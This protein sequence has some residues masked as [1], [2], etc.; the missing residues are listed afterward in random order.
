MIR[1]LPPSKW[2][3][4]KHVKCIGYNLAKQRLLTYTFKD[5]QIYIQ[6]IVNYSKVLTPLIGNS[7]RFTTPSAEVLM[8]QSQN[9][10]KLLRTL[11]NHL[12]SLAHLFSST[13]LLAWRWFTEYLPKAKHD[14]HLEIWTKA[15][16]AHFCNVKSSLKFKLGNHLIIH[17]NL[18]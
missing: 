6:T 14:K 2:V 9:V 8:E 1:A 10:L 12:D 4:P 17:L 16:Y 7:L 11:L 3:R 15:Q 13:C 5:S 18:N